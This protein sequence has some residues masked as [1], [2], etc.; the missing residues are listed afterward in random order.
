MQ[1]DRAFNIDI[2]GLRTG[3]HDYHFD[4]EDK[5][6]E[7]YENSLVE[8]GRGV[9]D[10]VLKKTDTM[11]TLGFSIEGS[12]ELVCDRSEEKFDYP[13]SLKDTLILKYGDELDKL[14]EDVWIIPGGM[15]A[16]NI[17]ENIYELIGVAIPMKKLHPK[18]GEDDSEGVELV[19]TSE[20]E[21]TDEETLSESID[22]RWDVLKKLKK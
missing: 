11:I 12:I 20:D 15:Q 21:S 4:F 9:C 1:G 18:F 10:V 16:I 5:L 3:S 19:Y 8:K 2:F 14:G 6:F 17:E 22:P 13:L 7:N